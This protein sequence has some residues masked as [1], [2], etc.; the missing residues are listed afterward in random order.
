MLD[1]RIA[2]IYVR[3]QREGA[4]QM[5]TYGMYNVCVVGFA[6]ELFTVYDKAG[7]DCSFNTL[8]EASNLCNEKFAEDGR[9]YVVLL[10]SERVYDCDT[11]TGYKR[12]YLSWMN[13]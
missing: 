3:F 10:R 11:A 5:T 9:H 1:G 6:G 2:G 7:K 4:E 13:G 12:E 8:E